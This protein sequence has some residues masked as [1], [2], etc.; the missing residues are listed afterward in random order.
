MTKV[1]HIVGNGDAFKF[2]K[3]PSHGLIMTCNLPPVENI[4]NVYATA[5]VYF[6]MCNAIREGSINLS[7]FDWVC[8]ARPKRYTEMNPDFYLKYSRNIKEFYLT[9]PKYVAN[10]T[11]F[12]CGHFCTHYVANKLKC[13]EIHMYG[14]DSIFDFNLVSTTDLV[15]NSP[16]DAN[17]THRLAQNWRPIWEGLF[18]EFPDTQFV[19]YHN[20]GHPKINLPKNVDV[21]TGWLRET[22]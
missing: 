21:R 6:K 11:D 16:R 15:L 17:N 3:Q 7:M 22:G 20:H 18:R 1:A 9:L 13:N 12:N 14:F 10:Y 4:K 2:F 5:I 8:G 19:V